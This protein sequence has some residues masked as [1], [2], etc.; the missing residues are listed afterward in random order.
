MEALLHGPGGIAVTREPE[1]EEPAGP[2]F[3][4]LFAKSSRTRGTRQG[5]GVPIRSLGDAEL[6]RA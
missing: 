1:G 5:D 4:I 3:A 2:Y 6:Q